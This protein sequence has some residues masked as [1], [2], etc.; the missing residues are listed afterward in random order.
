MIDISKD[1]AALAEARI[2]IERAWMRK[3]LIM[4]KLNTSEEG[5]EYLRKQ[6]RLVMVG[7]QSETKAQ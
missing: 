3:Q 7:P 5:R 1:V 6:I 2:A 4:G